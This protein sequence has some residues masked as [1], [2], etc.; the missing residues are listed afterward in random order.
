MNMRHHA[1]SLKFSVR[2]HSLSQLHRLRGRKDSPLSASQSDIDEAACDVPQ[3]G[4]AAN[5]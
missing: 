2:F 1:I 3:S 4:V 5:L